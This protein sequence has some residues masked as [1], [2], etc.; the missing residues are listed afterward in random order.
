MSA[1]EE[2]QIHY[3]YNIYKDSHGYLPHKLESHTPLCSQ[4]SDI[5]NPESQY[6]IR[7]QTFLVEQEINFPTV[8]SRFRWLNIS[9]NLRKKNIN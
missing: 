2:W 3:Q 6:Y 8:S 1:R 7:D 5:Y 9:N 4:V